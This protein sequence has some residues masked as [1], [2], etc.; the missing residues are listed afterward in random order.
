M[1]RVWRLLTVGIFLWFFYGYAKNVEIYQPREIVRDYSKITAP[2]SAVLLIADLPERQGVPVEFDKGENAEPESETVWADEAQ[3]QP[4]ISI[5][6][7]ELVNK[8]RIAEIYDEDVVSDFLS[9]SAKMFEREYDKNALYERDI[10][11]CTQEAWK[12]HEEQLDAFSDPKDYYEVDEIAAVRFVNAGAADMRANVETA[13]LESDRDRVF[14]QYFDDY[15]VSMYFGEGKEKQGGETE[16][17]LTEFSFVRVKLSEYDERETAPKELYERLERKYYRDREEIQSA[18]WAV[19]PEGTK[20]V[21]IS[22]GML[23]KHP[24][25]IFVRYQEK[26][27]DLI[28]RRTWECYFTAWVDENHF[29]CCDDMSGPFLIHLEDN[30]IEDIKKEDD[31][32]DQWG[33]KYRVEN[34]QLIATFLD[35]EY[36]RWDI[37][38]D[39][40]HMRKAENYDSG[41][42]Y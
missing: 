1:K 27:P 10:L 11:Y 23:P 37:V 36:Y 32:Y 40:I 38:N 12:Y 3:E 14:V 17:K 5:D 21:C 7:E 26:M 16:L 19:S 13:V 30:R 24:S 4:E 29:I 15:A 9:M 28:F 22:N 42:R 18:E 6:S 25:Q 20:A 8:F 39:E 2:V 35:E 34:G 31:D 41:G 33:C